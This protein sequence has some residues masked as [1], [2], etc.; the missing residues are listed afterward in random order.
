MR[1]NNDKPMQKNTWDLSNKINRR[2]NVY[3]DNIDY[4]ISCKKEQ[5]LDTTQIDMSASW[6][7]QRSKTAN[8]NKNFYEFK[9]HGEIW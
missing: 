8:N 6:K 4:Y 7:I 1:K 9:K 3:S 5:D 2:K